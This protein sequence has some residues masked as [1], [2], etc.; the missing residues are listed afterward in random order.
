MLFKISFYFQVKSLLSNSYIETYYEL[1]NTIV[2]KKISSQKNN[3]CCNP[4]LCYL[5]HLS[6]LCHNYLNC[7]CKGKLKICI[8]LR[9]CMT[10]KKNQRTKHFCK[11][12]LSQKS[13]KLENL[14]TSRSRCRTEKK[15]KKN[16]KQF[17]FP[18]IG[19]KMLKIS[20]ILCSCEIAN[21]MNTGSSLNNKPK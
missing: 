3:F 6:L 11:Q 1:N 14:T 21:Q 20:A 8:H 17:G 5:F 7:E 10:D 2:G 13:W 18:C 9:L 16:P 19:D 12:K 15:S 4:S